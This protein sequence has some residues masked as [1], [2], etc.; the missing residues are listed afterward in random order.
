M[1][2]VNL[3]YCSRQDLWQLWPKLSW[4]QWTWSKSVH[5]LFCRPKSADRWHLF[6]LMPIDNILQRYIRYLWILLP[7]LPHL[8]RQP[9][10]FLYE[11]PWRLL[12]THQP[13]GMRGIM[14]SNG[15]GH[16][17]AHQILLGLSKQYIC[18]RGSLS[19]VRC[20]LCQMHI[21]IIRWLYWMQF[22]TQS[23]LRNVS[24]PIGIGVHRELPY[25]RLYTIPAFSHSTLSWPMLL[26]AYSSRSFWSSRQTSSSVSRS[27]KSCLSSTTSKLICLTASCLSLSI[28][29]YLTSTF[30][31][32]LSGTL[33]EMESMAE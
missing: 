10:Q 30:W 27:S 9:D 13:D 23:G 7:D 14:R 21:I 29:F 11:L 4:L 3:P 28:F 31:F 18:F 2:N 8:F 26:Y 12:P 5:S 22:R 19:D 33:S 24:M 6:W 15:I 1:S 17:W 20:E 32:H 25:G 16:F